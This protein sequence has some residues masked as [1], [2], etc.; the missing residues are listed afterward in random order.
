MYANTENDIGSADLM[1]Y[2]GFI[3]PNY[4]QGG[5]IA[6]LATVCDGDSY[7]K[8]K[9]SINNYGTSHSSMGELLAHEVGHN[10]GKLTIRRS[11]MLNLLIY[12]LPPLVCDVYSM[13]I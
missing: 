10:L 5:G 6:Y 3:G 2:M 7:R 1:L 12:A 13:F 4:S 8:Y 11:Y 9:Q